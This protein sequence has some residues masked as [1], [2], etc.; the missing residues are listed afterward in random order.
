[1]RWSL[2]SDDA[3]LSDGYDDSDDVISIGSDG[4]DTGGDDDDNSGDDDD[5]DDDDDDD[6]DDDIDDLIFE[7]AD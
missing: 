7:L 1:V 6:D 2:F 3:E 4:D 5:G